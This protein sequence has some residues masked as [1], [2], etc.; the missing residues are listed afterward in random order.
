MDLTGATT[1][2]L[3]RE[4][5][6]RGKTPEGRVDLAFVVQ[7][8]MDSLH[9]MN[10]VEI[11]DILDDAEE[12]ALTLREMLQGDFREETSQDAPKGDLDMT[13]SQWSALG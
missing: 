8:L 9:D 4:I 5:V 6:K 10:D 2:E 13:I 12:F 7:Q 3:A 1:Q 11:D